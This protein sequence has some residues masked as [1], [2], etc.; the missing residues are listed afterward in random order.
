VISSA[1]LDRS[2]RGAADD[3]DVP[4]AQLTQRWVVPD[5]FAAAAVEVGMGSRRWVT[6]IDARG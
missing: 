4:P 2:S 6:P 1:R 3:A 5:G